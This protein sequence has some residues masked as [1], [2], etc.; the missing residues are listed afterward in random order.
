MA[1]LRTE[2][3]TTAAS[4]VSKG[5]FLC[6]EVVAMVQTAKPRHRN[7]LRCAAGLD[8]QAI[9]RCL[10]CQSKVR[11][12]VMVVTDVIG[13]QAFEMP[14]I[15]CDDMIEEVS[16]AVADEAFRDSVLPPA[17]EAGAFRFDAEA[18]DRT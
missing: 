8:G 7:N 17:A 15:E 10:L 1:A 16:A 6:R 13:H 12:V 3:H 14:F 4:Q 2:R 5:V 18:L 11:S 9:C